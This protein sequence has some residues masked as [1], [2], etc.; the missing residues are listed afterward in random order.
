MKIQPI[1]SYRESVLFFVLLRMG[2]KLFITILRKK[3]LLAVFLFFYPTKELLV[4][5]P[6]IASALCIQKP[7]VNYIKFLF[8]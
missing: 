5:I 4:F 1:A 3:M 8:L 7:G 6:F 2:R